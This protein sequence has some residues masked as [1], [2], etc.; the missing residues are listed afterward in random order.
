MRNIIIGT[1]IVYIF[2]FGLHVQKRL[3]C[4]ILEIDNQNKKLNISLYFLIFLLSS[5]LCLD[6]ISGKLAFVFSVVM[7]SVCILP[8]YTKRAFLTRFP[9]SFSVFFVLLPL[10]IFCAIMSFHSMPAA[11]GWYSYYGKLINEYKQMPYKD[12]EL[13]FMPVYTYIIA[14]FTKIFGY[15]IIVLRILGIIIYSLIAIVSFFLF[16]KIFNNKQTS[17]ISSIITCLFMQ[18]EIVQIFYDYIRVFDLFT[19]LSALMLFIFCRSWLDEKN[20]WN[21]ICLLLSGISAVIAFGIRQNSGAFVIVFSVLFICFVGCYKNEFKKL[22]ISLSIYII[23]VLIPFFIVLLLMAK[24][25][26][27]SIFLN[28]TV[29]SAIDA[30]GGFLVVLFAWIP[31]FIKSIFHSYLEVAFFIIFLAINIVLFMF[32]KR[33]E[34]PKY[35]KQISCFF[36]MF[37]VLGIALVYFSTRFSSSFIELR[38]NN[39][40]VASYCVCCLCFLSSFAILIIQKFQI[41]KIHISKPTA[42]FSFNIMFISGMIVAIGYG[43]G[44]SSGLSEGQTALAIGL[45]VELAFYFSNHNFSKSSKAIILLFCYILAL[46]IISQKFQHP[47]NWWGLEEVSI[48]ESKTK[49]TDIDELDGLLLSE[50]TADGMER[51]TKDIRNNSKKEDYIFCF[52]QIPIFYVLSDRTSSTY[53]KVQWFDVSNYDSILKDIKTLSENLPKV[54]VHMKVDPYVIESHEKLFMGGGQSGL[55]VMDKFLDTLESSDYELVDSLVLQTYPVSVY[56]RIE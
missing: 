16:S 22:I 11:E 48:K 1:L 24:S 9:D 45:L 38:I 47:Y 42:S 14:F 23:S 43:C 29:N 6:N 4:G 34:N 2:S 37:L 5:I 35:N 20:R 10:V 30:K 31:R 52:P 27:L 3:F 25:G 51:I 54:I 7:V 32:K 55:N 49:I 26:C 56:V 39:L 18:S 19:Y 28:S 8:V 17:V 41:R 44:T 53:T 12:F 50:S 40:P 36:S 15:K 33:D 13:L 21:N 46:S